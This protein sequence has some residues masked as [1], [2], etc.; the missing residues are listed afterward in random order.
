MERLKT[1]VWDHKVPVL[2][3]IGILIVLI[4]AFALWRTFYYDNKKIVLGVDV[5]AYQ[6][7]IDWEIISEQGI[8]F[9]YIKAT[10]GTDFID[11]RF[12][13]NWT[14]ARKTN[15][16]VGAYFFVNFN[17][18]GKDQAKYFIKNVPKESG[19]FPPVIDL[20]LYGDYLDN[21]PQKEKVNT[22]LKEMIE[23]LKEKYGEIPIIY[24]NY[25]TYNQYLSNAF[26]E[27]PIWICDI[28]SSNP[29]LSG[30]HKWVFWQYS[31]RQILQGYDGEE[32]FIDMNVFNGDT[33][34]F[35]AMFN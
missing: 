35:K 21:P 24:T 18:G 9:A 10:E 16:K 23:T 29:E 4:I 14:A 13:E 2:I 27:V 3:G 32:R 25:N 26:T 17:K 15:L 28:S 22:M 31:Q 30:G 34:A 1:W 20:E 33:K 7:E 8:S 19:S 11:K 6:G 5:S 12:N